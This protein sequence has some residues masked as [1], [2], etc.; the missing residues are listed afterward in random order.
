MSTYSDTT[1]DDA[2]I[3][4]WLARDQ[5]EGRASEVSIL[6]NGDGRIVAVSESV[7]AILGRRPSTLV[8]QT[9]EVLWSGPPDDAS[10]RDSLE[11]LMRLRRMAGTYRLPA[12]SGELI[13]FEYE[14]LADHPVRGLHLTTLRRRMRES[15]SRGLS[16]RERDVLRM[17]CEG[18]PD[19]TIAGSLGVTPGVVRNMRR[20]AYQ[21]LKAA[22]LHEACVLLE[23]P[24]P[25]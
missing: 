19:E 10:R 17:T 14:S 18:S 5:A 2:L 3:N 12:F 24:F 6:T 9:I 4:G 15:P 22:D 20:H 21:K 1:W 7:M 16:E 13:V 25:H 23:H 11:R 8:G